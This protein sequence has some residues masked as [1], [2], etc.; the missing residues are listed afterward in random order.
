MKRIIITSLISPTWSPN[1]KATSTIE[2]NMNYRITLVI[3]WV[4]CNEFE[5]FKH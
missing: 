3:E 4:T 1:V 5:G 2:Q